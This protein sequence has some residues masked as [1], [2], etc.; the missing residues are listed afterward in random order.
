MNSV[1]SVL[2]LVEMSILCYHLLFVE[3]CVCVLCDFAVNKK[4]YLTWYEPV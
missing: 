4:L 3:F 1:N 2:W